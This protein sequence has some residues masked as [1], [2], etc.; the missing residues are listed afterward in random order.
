LAKSSRV[1][2][3]S[4]AALAVETFEFLDHLVLVV[5]QRAPVVV[6]F[7]FVRL[8]GVFDASGLFKPGL[9]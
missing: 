2:A 6:Q 9:Q 7:L 4:P 8:A 1:S 5:Y 3:R